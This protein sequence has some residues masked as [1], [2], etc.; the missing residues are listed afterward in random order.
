MYVAA[1]VD[2]E[3][4]VGCKLC[5]QAC[6]EPNAIKLIINPDKKKKTL[7]TGSRCKGCGLCEVACTKKAITLRQ[8]VTSAA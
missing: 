2:M 4:C 1:F 7:I 5:I 3:K 6:P 8:I